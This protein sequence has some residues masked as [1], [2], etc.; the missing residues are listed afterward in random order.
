MIKHVDQLPDGFFDALIDGEVDPFDVGDD[1]TEWRGK[2]F[3][4]VLYDGERAIAHVGLTLADVEIGAERFTV[5]GVGGVVVNR[6][7]RG[8]GRLR[9]LM[10][11][12]LARGLGPERAMLFALAKNQ[13]IYERFGFARIDARVSAGGQ[14]MSGQAMWKPLRG[15]VAWP[16][17]P[18]NLPQLPF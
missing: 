4:T 3:H 10:D 6:S 7:Y 15:G 16:G 17:G 18:V 11:A 1:R 2:E 5:V 14:D 9:P 8:Q 12:A 13:P